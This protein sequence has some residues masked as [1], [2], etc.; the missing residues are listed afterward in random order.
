M[1][2]IEK[3]ATNYKVDPEQFLQPTHPARPAPIEGRLGDTPTVWYPPRPGGGIYYI[4][5]SLSAG[6]PPSAYI[7]RAGQIPQIG[8]GLFQGNE[9]LLLGAA[10]SLT[11]ENISLSH[12]SRIRGTLLTLA[13]KYHILLYGLTIKQQ[14]YYL[15]AS[16]ARDTRLAGEL[17]EDFQYLGIA[18]RSLN[19]IQ[20]EGVRQ[21]FQV[22]ET[23]GMGV[24]THE[25]RQVPFYLAS[26]LPYP[27]IEI[28][29]G[30]VCYREY[31]YKQP[32][33]VDTSQ[34]E[35]LALGIL[36]MNQATGGYSAKA[37]DFASG[38]WLGVINNRGI[39]HLGLTSFRGGVIP[40][41]QERLIRS[42]REYSEYDGSFY[43]RK[44]FHYPFRGISSRK[45]K[46]LAEQAKA[47][48]ES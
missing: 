13:Q 15:I 24:T 23:F 7:V 47:Y 48:F 29:R 4:D 30:K 19:S 44:Y 43:G 14:E 37:P 10:G 32:P 33:Q 35:D 22:P 27:M 46:M 25:D 34:L 20:D 16:L 5:Y 36:V 6:S 41:T 40:L 45:M 21:K 2:L 17:Q 3:Q 9:N 11:A 18:R 1:S 42:L 26:F 12:I 8:L 38:D 31:Q 39:L 28:S